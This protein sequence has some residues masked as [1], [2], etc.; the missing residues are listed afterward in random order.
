M[1]WSSAKAHQLLRKNQRRSQ[2][3][4]EHQQ[5]RSADSQTGLQMEQMKSARSLHLHAQRCCMLLLSGYL[6]V[7]HPRCI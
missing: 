4:K 5:V 6:L 2:Q 7:Q 3:Q 1:V